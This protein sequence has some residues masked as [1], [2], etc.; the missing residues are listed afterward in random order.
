VDVATVEVLVRAAEGAWA[1]HGRLTVRTPRGD[2]E[3][4]GDSSCLLPNESQEAAR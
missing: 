1:R 2:W 4:P 3:G